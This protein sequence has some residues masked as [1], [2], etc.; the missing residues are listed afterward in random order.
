V[1]VRALK[2]SAGAG[3]IDLPWRRSSSK[4]FSNSMNAEEEKKLR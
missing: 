2:M 3:R 4:N 1:N